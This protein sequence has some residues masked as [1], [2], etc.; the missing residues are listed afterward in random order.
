MTHIFGNDIL[1]YI[2]LNEKLLIL[3]WMSMKF[4]PIDNDPR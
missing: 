2:F 1:K 4:V 3:L